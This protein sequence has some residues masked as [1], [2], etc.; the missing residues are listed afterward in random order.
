LPFE[1][2][3]QGEAV[4]VRTRAVMVSVV[5]PCRDQVAGMTQAE[6]LNL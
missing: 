5:T 2:F 3:R 1:E 6:D 4:E